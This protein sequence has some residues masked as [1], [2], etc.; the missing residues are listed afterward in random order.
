MITM[1]CVRSVEV[2]EELVR[3]CSL[4]DILVAYQ[5]WF[6]DKGESCGGAVFI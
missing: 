4:L 2:V 5:A 6:V 1:G 3:N